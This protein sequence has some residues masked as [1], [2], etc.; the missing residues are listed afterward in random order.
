MHTNTYFDI[1]Q[2]VL[3][4]ALQTPSRC[5]IT[6]VVGGSGHQGLPSTLPSPGQADFWEKGYLVSPGPSAEG[7]GWGGPAPPWA[8]ARRRRR[9]ARGGEMLPTIN[10]ANMERTRKW[11]KTP[12]T[13]IRL[14]IYNDLSLVFQKQ[15]WSQGRYAHSG[16]SVLPTTR[17]NGKLGE[18][19]YVSKMKI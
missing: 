5:H 10:L 17:T 9:G 12:Q 16:I 3:V 13:K 7:P 1:H 19:L 4:S 8:T 11:E 14:M 18:I 6:L 15:G 2:Y